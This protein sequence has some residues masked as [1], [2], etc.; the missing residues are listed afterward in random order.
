MYAPRV[1]MADSS[2]VC[3]QNDIEHIRER[4]CQAKKDK[5]AKKVSKKKSINKQAYC[6]NIH[7][8]KKQRRNIYSG[9]SDKFDMLVKVDKAV[10]R[11]K[12]LDG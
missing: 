2:P 3:L 12:K 6:K 1:D 8:V 7:Q 10:E 9:N 11:A 4:S 5:E